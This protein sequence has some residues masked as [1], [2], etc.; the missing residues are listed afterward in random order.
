M[1]CLAWIGY[2]SVALKRRHVPGTPFELVFASICEGD[3]GAGD[4]V[5]NGS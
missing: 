4:E 3:G 5:D 2:A 1:R